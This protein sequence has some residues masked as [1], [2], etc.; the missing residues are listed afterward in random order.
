MGNQCFKFFIPLNKGIGEGELVG[1][2]STL[3]LDR[4]SEKMSSKALD[5]MEETIN[6]MGVNLFLDHN[7]GVF[8]TIGAV[9][10]ARREG[11]ELKV[12][13][14]LDDPTT[15]LNV[16]AILNKLKRGIKLGLSVGGNVTNEKWEYDRELGK[17]IK[18]IDE[19]N[20][21]EISLVGIPSNP[22]GMVSIPGQIMKSLKTERLN[23]K[24][25]LCCYTE[26]NSEQ[27]RCQ[28]CYYPNQIIK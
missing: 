15:N 22:D 27:K 2:A 20:L 18:V 6:T 17:K 23:S 25:C 10:K 8:D 28:T 16:P 24:K 4:D 9:K 3:S 26:I 19:V 7:H 11:N 14:D 12:S 21:F 13:I 1:V 5:Q